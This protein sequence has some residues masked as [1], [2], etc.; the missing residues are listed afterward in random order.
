[1]SGGA[2]AA[3][4]TALGAFVAAAGGLVVSVQGNR[5][6]KATEASA[7]EA[8]KRQASRE[9]LDQVIDAQRDYIAWGTEQL[10]VANDR[11]SHLSTDLENCNAD[12]LAMRLR[13]EE[14]IATLR[15]QLQALQG[16]P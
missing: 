4:I 11:I 12:K 2:I 5:R 6:T 8:A 14:E 3:I 16:E 7:A 13:F 10:R 1:M 9:D 15:R